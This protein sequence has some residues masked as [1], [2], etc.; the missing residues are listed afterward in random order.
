MT[1]DDRQMKEAARAAA[2][3]EVQRTARELLEVMERIPA[4]SA[5]SLAEIETESDTLRLHDLAGEHGL[6]FEHEGDTYRFDGYTAYS[7]PQALG[8][9][10]GVDRA[11]HYTPPTDDEIDNWILGA[12]Y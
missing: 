11:R 2:H 9:A 3:A 12:D 1:D 8:Y 10:E 4:F 6:T 7:L 5:P